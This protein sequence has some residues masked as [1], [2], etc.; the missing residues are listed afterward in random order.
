MLQTFGPYTPVRRAG[1]LLFVSGQVGVD[2][3]TRTA[4]TDVADQTKQVLSNLRDVLATI[5]ASLDDVVKTTIYLQN[6]DDFAAVNQVY[7]QLFNT[8][9]P[10]RSTVEVAALPEVA[11]GTT[12]LV[13]IEAVAWK[14][15]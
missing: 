3:A 10:A 11:G 2:P 4:P 7:E 9:R 6:I 8:P 5:H 12:L 1:N 14:E 15:S 13:E